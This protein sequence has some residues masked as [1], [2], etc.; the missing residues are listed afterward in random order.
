MI[1]WI[2]TSWLSIKNS[3]SGGQASLIWIIGHYAERIDNAQELLEVRVV[4]LGRSTCHAISG[5][6]D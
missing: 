2:R 4:H 5:R 6:R 1:K 3:L